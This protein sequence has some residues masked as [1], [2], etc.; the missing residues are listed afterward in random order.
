M[1]EMI[2]VMEPRRLYLQIADRI[3]QLIRDGHFPAGSRLPAERELAL[4]LGVSRPSLREALIALEIAGNVEVRMGSGIYATAELE[5]RPNIF[6]GSMGE[7]PLEIIQARSVIEGSAIVLACHQMSSEALERLRA[8]LDAMQAQI[9]LSRKAIELDRQ[10]HLI[11]AEQT[12]NSVVTRMVRDLFDERHKPLTAQMRTRFETDD[13]WLL[14]FEEHEKIYAAL[15]AKDPF[16]AQAAM[17][18]HLDMSKQ[19]WMENEPL[20]SEREVEI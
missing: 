9:S 10:F 3:R 16:M 19:R 8:N 1:N 6:G 17:R 12:G 5:E 4:L 18:M 2:G 11:I 13:T 14:A 7:S 15:E 20:R